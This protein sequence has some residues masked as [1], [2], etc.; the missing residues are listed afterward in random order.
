METYMQRYYRKNSDRLKEQVKSYRAKHPEKVAE[1]A[2]RRR[3]RY[4]TDPEMRAKAI[5]RSKAH[6]Y[7]NRERRSAYD[8]AR[9]HVMRDVLAAK[10]LARF[11]LTPAT[12]QE[13]LDAQGGRCAICLAE[14][15]GSKGRWHIDHDHQC[16]PS[17]TGCCGRCVRGLLCS[18]CNCGL[19]QFKDDPFLLVKASY[20][21]SA[22]EARTA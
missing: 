7:A 2:E 10:R 21:L 12:Y 17:K 11:G 6:Y 4:A 22:S 3:Q 1:W 18:S 5:E 13:I 8:K 20:Y 15:L 9:R 14:R 16:C 19:G